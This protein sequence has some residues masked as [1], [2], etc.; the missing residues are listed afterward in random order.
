MNQILH[1]YITGLS[2][3]PLLR[4]EDR[5]SMKFSIEARAPFADDINLIEYVFQIPSVYKIYSGWSKYLLRSATKDLLPEQIRLRKDK[6]GF[7]TPESDWLNERKDVFKNYI[8]GEMSEFLDVQ[9]MRQDWDKLIQS[10]LKDGIT[11]LWRFINL[12]VWKKVYHL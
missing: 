4:Y 8:T 7:A 3:K 10:Q 5:N 6:I 11:T 12:A 1:E 2:L 9:E